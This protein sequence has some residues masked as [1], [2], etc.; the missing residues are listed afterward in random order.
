MPIPDIFIVTACLV[1]LPFKGIR[2]KS[3]CGLYHSF[4]TFFHSIRPHE[5]YILI[6]LELGVMRKQSIVL[7]SKTAM[8]SSASSGVLAK[9]WLKTSEF[10]RIPQKTVGVLLKFKYKR[11]RLL[12]R[13]YGFFYIL[14]FFFKKL[15]IKSSSN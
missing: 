15:I 11:M 8:P 14:C 2:T 10:R 7:S 9:F 3:A 13:E 12:A 1:R 6:H 5:Y 4:C